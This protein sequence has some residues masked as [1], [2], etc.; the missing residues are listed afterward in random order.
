MPRSTPA[1]PRGTS[2]SSPSRG[3]AAAGARERILHA[4]DELFYRRGVRN[5]GI[6]EI[7]A[8]AGVAK[9]SLYKHFESK[10]ALVAEYLRQRNARWLAWFV[11]AVERSADDPRERLLAV[12]QILEEW[13]AGPDFRGCAF[14]N[15]AVELADRRHEGHAAALANKQAVRAYLKELAARAGLRDPAAVSEELAVLA[16]GATILA[17]LEGSPAAGRAARRAAATLLHAA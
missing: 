11:E 7:I 3:L 9:A 10:D 6:D 15:A 14:Q 16:E 5:V 4:A 12:F 8:V 17:L 13:L 1:A 2:A